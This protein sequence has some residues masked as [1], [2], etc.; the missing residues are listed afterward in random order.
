MKSKSTFSIVGSGGSALAALLVLTGC[1]ALDATPEHLVYGK[2]NAIYIEHAPQVFV[3]TRV[4]S[5]DALGPMWADV[6]LSSPAPD[7]RVVARVRLNEFVDLKQGDE[8][9][10]DW[11][12]SSLALAPTARPHRIVAVLHRPETASAHQSPA[13]T[14]LARN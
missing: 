1:T 10:I 3:D 13:K 7:G 6:N 12:E 11:S 2:V 8:I 4:A 14:S 5:R 9:K